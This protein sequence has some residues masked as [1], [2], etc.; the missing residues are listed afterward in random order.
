[1]SAMASEATLL[2]VQF[3]R[4][5]AARPRRYGEMREAWGSTCPLNCAWEDAIAD[6]LVQ[7]T[8]DGHLLLTERGRALLAAAS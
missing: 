7:R 6:D 2:R 1:M 8:A 5:L 4:W 3:L